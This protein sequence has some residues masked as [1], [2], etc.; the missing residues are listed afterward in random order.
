MTESSV[1]TPKLVKGLDMT[2]DYQYD[3]RKLLSEMAAEDTHAFEGIYEHY[4]VGIYQYIVKVVKSPQ[5]AEDVQQEVFIKLW[6]IRSKLPEVKNFPSFLF[7]IARNHTINLMRSIARSNLAL[8]DLLRN[9]PEPTADSEILHRDYERFIDKTLQSLPARTREIYLK[10]KG[11][12]RSYEEVAQELGISNSAIK[13]HVVN[14]I[15]K[16]K[17]AAHNELGLR[18]EAGVYVLAVLVLAAQ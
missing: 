8:G 16:L 5:L 2:A 13:R 7:T 11:Q 9:A 14:S 4:R 18:P 3:E 17:E 12:G 1:F 6:E 15:K 10:C